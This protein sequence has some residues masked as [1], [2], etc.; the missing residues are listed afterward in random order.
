MKQLPH[1]SS[2]TQ[3]HI[4]LNAR[5]SFSLNWYLNMWGHLKFAYEVPRWTTPNQITLNWTKP[6][7]CIA[8]CHVKSALFRDIM[9]CR[10]VIPYWCFGITY[11]PHLCTSRNSR[12]NTV[13]LKLP[14]SIFFCGLCPSISVVRQ[15]SPEPGV[16]LRLICS[17]SLNTTETV[18]FTICTWEEILSK[19]S[20]RKNGY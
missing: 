8:T 4:D 5:W 11:R 16:P 14:N 2:M 1:M 17:Q 7:A 13:R 19:S 6:K 10:V 15:R 18:T 20:T 12:E 3:Y 9:Q